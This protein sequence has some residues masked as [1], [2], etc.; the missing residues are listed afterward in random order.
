MTRLLL[1]QGEWWASLTDG[2]PLWQSILGQG[3]SAAA[4]QQMEFLITQRVN[5][6]PF[7]IGT[8]NVVITFNQQ[9]RQFSYSATVNTSFGAIQLSNIPIPGF[10]QPNG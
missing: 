9:T 8:E 3:A 1:F 10:L 5:G 2:L 7:V 6:T 4:Q